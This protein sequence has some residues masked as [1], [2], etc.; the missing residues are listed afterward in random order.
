MPVPSVGAVEEITIKTFVASI[1]ST[2]GTRQSVGVPC[3]MDHVPGNST[4]VE[5][6]DLLSRQ[7]SLSYSVSAPGRSNSRTREIPMQGSI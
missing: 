4:C 7:L 2:L 3:C 1:D 6:A 5:C